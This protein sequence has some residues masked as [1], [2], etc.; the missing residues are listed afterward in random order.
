MTDDT[1]WQNLDSAWWAKTQ[2]ARYHIDNLADE[3]RAFMQSKPYEILINRGDGETI[4]R[5]QMHRPIPV[6]LSTIIGDALHNLRSALDCAAFDLARWHVQREGQRDLTEPE[7]RACQFPIC[8]T[9]A[10][11]DKFFSGTRATLYGPREREAMR[12]VQPARVHDYLAERGQPTHYPREEE[13]DHDPLYLLNKLS[14]IDKHRRLHLAFW[15]PWMASWG[16]DAP[17]RRQWRWGRPPFVD[18]AILGR[19]S[20]DPEGREP[21]PKVQHELSL[22]ILYLAPYVED[23]VKLLTSFHNNVTGWVLPRVFQSIT[24]QPRGADATETP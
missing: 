7:E 16:S 24:A 9:Q 21:L 4:Y 8:E 19:L 14:N 20:D 10:A 13:V 15:W 23:V 3:I 12:G 22:S 6:S 1:W 2:R 17:S 5:L 18:G 11:F